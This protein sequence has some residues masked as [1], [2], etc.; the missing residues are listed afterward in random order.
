MSIYG[1]IKKELRKSANPIKAKLLQGFFKTG[2]NEYGQGDVFLGITVPE[3]RR[4]IKKYKKIGLVDIENLLH[5]KIHEERLAGLLALV[6]LYD[7]GGE[8]E[9]KTIFR[10]YITNLKQVNNWDLVDLTAHRIIGGYLLNRPKIILYKLARSKNLWHK[11]VTIISTFKFIKYGRFSD[12]L[13]IAS[14]LLKDEHDLIHK[15]VGWM[16]REVGKKSIKSEEDFLK[17][18]Y[19]KMPRTMLRYAIEKFPEKKRLAY[20]HNEI[21]AA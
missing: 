6:N 7:G 18:H 8:S 5:S 20:L 3:V 15:A 1:E 19:R 14:L 11:R 12:S 16:L 17:R 13:K 21:K 4:I 2:K 10:F 9:K